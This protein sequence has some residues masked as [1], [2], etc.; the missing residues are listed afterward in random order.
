MFQL[1]KTQAA[2]G[3]NSIGKKPFEK[4][5]ESPLKLPNTKIKF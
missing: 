2:Q 5:L 3:P 4:P 1:L